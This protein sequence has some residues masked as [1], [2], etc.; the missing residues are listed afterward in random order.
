MAN[1]VHIHNKQALV[2][3]DMIALGK[4]TDCQRAIAAEAAARRGIP[5]A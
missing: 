5:M 1:D 4:R 2:R 3:S